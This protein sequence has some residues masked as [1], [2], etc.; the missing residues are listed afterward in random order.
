[1]GATAVSAT[2][3]LPGQFRFFAG[4][5]RSVR[6]F[7]NAELSPSQPDPV[8][9]ERVLVGGRYLLTGTV[10]LERDLPR[11]LGVATF[12]DFGN[13]MDHFSDPLAY[14]AGVGFRWRLPGITLGIDVA[15]A[16]RAPGYDKLPGPRIHLN[17]ALRL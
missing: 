12:V 6:G 14:A 15:Q 3:L 16:L 17:I 10:E 2:N 5:D 4:G 13:A 11:N 8:T 9:H 1:V 7:G